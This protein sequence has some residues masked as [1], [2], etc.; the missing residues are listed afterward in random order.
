MKR[1]VLV[2]LSVFLT[3]S[4]CAQTNGTKTHEV[5]SG[6]TL[7]S[8]ARAYGIS[9]KELLRLNPNLNPDYIMA[10]QKINVPSDVAL[11]DNAK[12]QEAVVNAIQNIVGS[13]ATVQ[14]ATA[15]TPQNNKPASAT[16]QKRPKYKTT[17]EVQ[18]KETL[19]SL[20]KL[21]NVTEEQI[22]SANP[23]LKGGKLKKG[24][25]I[26]IPYTDEENRKYQ[27]EQ[28]RLEEEARKPKVTRYS[29]IRVA[30]ILPF[31]LAS[32]QMTVEAQKMANLYQ[33]FLLAVDSLKSRGY[34]VEVYAYDETT[35]DIDELLAKPIMKNMQMILGPVRQQHTAV[36]GKY[37]HTHGIVNVVPLSSDIALVNEHPYTY[38][39]NVPSSSVYSQVYNRFISMHKDDNIIFIGMNDKADNTNYVIDFKKALDDYK[40]MY[41]RVSMTDFSTIKDMLKTT[42]R[43]VIVPS[44]GSIAAFDQLTSKLN[45][46]GISDEY[47]IQLF[48]FPE[49]Q[50]LP[51]KYEQ[52]M[53][54]YR[55]Q[56]FTTFFSNG[57]SQCTQSFNA[58]FREWFK[59]PQYNS[60]PKYGELGFDIGAFFIRGLRDYGSDINNNIH[61]ISYHSLEFPFNFEKKNSWSGFQNKA[62]NIVTYNQD[63]K[64]TVR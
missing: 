54:K 30:V 36:V 53:R 45:S 18:K 26:N 37:A 38:Q 28:R 39:V 12:S 58:K 11:K 8:I 57:E 15:Q 35:N 41:N 33:G 6:E 47:S 10:G 46:L 32:E 25:V 52:N 21:Y 7:S 51:S 29:T 22:I 61:N 63:G 42:N 3:L 55:C 59:Q 64:I 60:F 9:N 23:Q 43:N 34:S 19:Y 16:P 62:L 31:S 14:K 40:I 49:W 13:G 50:T 24:E 20:S 1:I 17:H 5:Q 2:L 27:E 48:G 4:I 56:F 44:S